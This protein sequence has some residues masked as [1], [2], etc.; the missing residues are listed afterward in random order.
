MGCKKGHKTLDAKSAVV[1]AAPVVSVSL[2]EVRY[3]GLYDLVEHE[4]AVTCRIYTFGLEMDT[5]YV[6][7]RDVDGLLAVVE[8]GKAVFEVVE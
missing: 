1:L 5:L 8:D 2:V 3:K 4:G 7:S 6:D